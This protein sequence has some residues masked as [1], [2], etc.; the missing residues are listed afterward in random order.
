MLTGDLTFTE[1]LKLE[2]II[3][4]LGRIACRQVSLL[5]QHV[6]FN[7]PCWVFCPYLGCR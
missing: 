3:L 1:L 5:A 2:H 4:A 6:E 7:F